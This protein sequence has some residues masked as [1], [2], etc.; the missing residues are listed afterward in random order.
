MSN[1]YELLGVPKTATQEDIKKAYRQK[2][3]Q[4]HP[5]RNPGD[6]VA[7]DMFK[8]VQE[9]YETLNDPLKRSMYDGGAHTMHFRRGARPRPNAGPK[10]AGFSFEEVMEEFFGGSTYKG[11]NIQF[12]VEIEFKEVM[13]GCVKQV[14]VKKRKRCT[15]CSG[16]GYTGF[17]PCGN[18]SG[19]GFTQV[20][21]APFEFRQA[22]VVC[23]GTGKA[24]TV[25]CA[26]CAGSGF[27]P[28]YHEYPLEIHIPP[29]IENGMQLRLAGEGEESL[30]GGRAGDVMIFVLVK[31]HPIFSREGP[32]LTVEVPVSYTQLVL[33]D[34]IEIPTL[35]GSKVKVK[36]PP[37]SQSHTKFRLKG[38]GFPGGKAGVGDLLATV[39]IETPK[40]TDEEY[41]KVLDQLAEME[42]KNVTPRREQWAKKSAQESK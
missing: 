8:K 35:D 4:Y 7:E 20:A 12:R 32:H 40:A 15:G 5:D 36:I 30:R 19:S 6:P 42:K 11:R 16:F 37:G 38:R 27:L 1:Y 23:G 17:T 18:C 2:A 22:C 31:D 13:T 25:K 14:K 34:E 21:D 26:D 3:R 24:A 29:G 39:K 41:K 28:G 10:P 33:G 9:A